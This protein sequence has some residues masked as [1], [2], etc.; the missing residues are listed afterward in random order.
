MNLEGIKSYCLLL[1][2]LRV[3]VSRCTGVSHQTMSARMRAMR[4]TL[5]AVGIAM[6]GYLS[7]TYPT[8]PL[9]HVVCPP[10]AAQVLGSVSAVHFKRLI[11][12]W[13]NTSLLSPNVC[14]S[15]PLSLFHQ[16]R[17]RGKA[18][19][20]SG[21]IIATDSCQGLSCLAPSPSAAG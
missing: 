16:R 10:L 7:P 17:S 15:L 2:V 13:L 14:T 6:Q 9:G 12:R 1:Q 4:A 19:A 18:A 3:P 11:V 8:V 5:H 20:V 21:V